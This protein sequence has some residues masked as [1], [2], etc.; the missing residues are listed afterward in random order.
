[1]SCLS[2]YVCHC[3][4]LKET[5]QYV[6]AS[7]ARQSDEVVARSVATRQSHTIK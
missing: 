6:V 4:R 5:W 1:M 7:E 3:E 2:G